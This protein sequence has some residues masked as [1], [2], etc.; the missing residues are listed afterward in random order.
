LTIPQE[1]AWEG[2][3]ESAWN[4]P[5]QEAWAAPEPSDWE[6]PSELV[7]PGAQ[8]QAAWG[9]PTQAGRDTSEPAAWKAPESQAWNASV[10]EEQQGQ[11]PSEQLPSQQT[12][13]APEQDPWAASGPQTVETPA[14]TAP[15]AP[16]QPLP[17]AASNPATLSE[18]PSYAPQRSALGR[19][20]ATPQATTPETATPQAA[21]PE[22]ATPQSAT[23]QAG[24]A[25]AAPAPGGASVNRPDNPIFPPVP[26]RREMRE[27]QAA[28]EEEAKEDKHVSRRRPIAAVVIV[29]LVAA[30]GSAGYF[31]GKPIYQE[32]TKPKEVQVTDFP[33]PGEGAASITIEA[34]DPGSVIG[35]KLVAAG[36][37]ATTGAFIEAWNKAGDRANSIQPGTYALM[38][39]MSA[40]GALAALLDPANRN[41]IMFTVPE[42]KRAAEVYQL[43]G[44]AV[45][46]SDL[47]DDA[48]QAALDQKAAEQAGVVKQ[49][50]ES[51]AIGLP[52]EANGL[53]EGWLYPET[54]SFN[55]D[56]APTEILSKMVA[57]TVKTLED[58]QVPRERWLEII[59]VASII[60]KEARLEPDR[61]KVARVIYNRLADGIKLELD[62]TVVYGVGRFDDTLSTTDAERNAD[63]PYT[64]YANRGLPIGAISD[65]GKAAIEAALNPTP[66]AWKFFCVVNPETGEMEFNETAEGH[67][68]SVEK[69]KQ[70]EREHAG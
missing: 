15:L 23:P 68:L 19:Q 18:P 47:G 53:V 62:S 13:E 49:A 4:S 48:D 11:E 3:N 51:G 36:V 37:I 65:P 21:T 41:A 29:L 58:L 30:V 60:E 54:Y 67:N 24:P 26:S 55:I 64:T 16:P 57:N 12:W 20:T 28:E 50:A 27:A 17:M 61:A 56:T 5:E 59:T 14:L 32:L 8:E 66:G 43:I 44:T 69:W 10:Q 38:E 45:A 46:K 42:G 33:G 2:S 63:N 1:P 22:T 40:S 7:A 34:G 31:L 35:D 6:D 70:W 9:A 25:Q 39:K 52:P